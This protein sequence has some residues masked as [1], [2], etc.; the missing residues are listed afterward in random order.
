MIA[1]DE[2]QSL[3]ETCE[4]SALRLEA[5]GHADIDDERAELAEFQAGGLPEAYSRE[6]D[7]WTRMLE[8]HAAA[9]RSFRRVRVLD[10]PLT[11]YNRYMIYTGMATVAVGEDIR[12]LARAEANALDLPDHDFWVF[13]SARLLELRFTA[14]GR[15]LGNDLITDPGVVA[16]HEDW[17]LRGLAAAT[18]ATDYLAEDPTRAWPPVR[19][20]AAKGT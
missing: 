14:D 12:Y 11:A 4:R 7:R 13:D 3:F 17:I 19:V 9:G 5:R 10:D 16:Q 6:P 8:R 18:P 2:A 20:G 1:A 15:F